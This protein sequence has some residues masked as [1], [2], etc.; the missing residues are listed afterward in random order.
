MK[1][2]FVT[3][4]EA[5]RYLGVHRTTLYNWEKRGDIKI[6]RIGRGVARIKTEDIKRIK[7]KAEIDSGQ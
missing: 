7:E 3:V 1:E 2:D 4:S 5:A 6:Y